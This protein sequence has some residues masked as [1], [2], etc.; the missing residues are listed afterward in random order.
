MFQG[1]FAPGRQWSFKKN[2]L[3]DARARRIFESTSLACTVDAYPFH[4]PLQAK[5]GP[6]VQADGHDMLM[7]SSYDYLGLIG[8]PRIDAAAAEAIHR[9]GT[10]TSGARLLTGTLDIHYQMEQD[11]AEFKGTEAALTFSSGYM[12]NL[13]LITGLFG[14]SDRVIIDSL[15]HRSLLDA[16]RMA[17]VQVQRFR[18]NDP[19]SLRE[20]LR[21][22]QPANR[23]LIVTDGVF[24]MDGDI[25]CLPDLI[26]IKKEFGCF[27]L[28][29]EAH[30]SG[31]LGANGRGTDEH[32]GIDTSEV[33]LWTGSLAKSIPSVGGFV[34]CSREV[35]I[36]LQHASYR[37]PRV[38][39]FGR[40]GAGGNQRRYAQRNQ[41][42]QQRGRILLNVHERQ[43]RPPPGWLRGPANRIT[44]QIA[45]PQQAENNQQGKARTQIPLPPFLPRLNEYIAEG[46]A[47]RH[48]SH[49]GQ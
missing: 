33:D 40:L 25:C 34:A 28:V 9:Y 7:M 27:L 47:E 43:D 21:G 23:T 26:A 1:Y 18:H 13:G 10:S 22:G 38:A 31:V 35:A 6:C 32:F 42:K 45:P 4:M 15:C 36:Y 14:P 37:L 48:H 17:G 29:D 39:S 8:H 12:A 19:E 5:A 11:L 16:C 41:K 46:V 24:S 2:D 20:E 30:A 44:I 3:L 49:P